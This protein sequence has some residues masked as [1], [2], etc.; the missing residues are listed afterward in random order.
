MKALGD[1]FKDFV[2]SKS[3]KVV[4]VA[5]GS[6]ET[7]RVTIKDNGIN[8][9]ETCAT[10][11]RGEVAM[12]RST[13]LTNNPNIT[14]CVSV[15]FNKGSQ[16]INTEN[17]RSV[18]ITPEKRLTEAKYEAWYE[19]NDSSVWRDKNDKCYNPSCNDKGNCKC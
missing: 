16:S 4:Q 2:Y 9:Q 8:Q 15:E 17:N 1:M 14:V 11:K 12:H 7:V 13:G 6:D 3:S 18:I 19:G 5:N 10:L